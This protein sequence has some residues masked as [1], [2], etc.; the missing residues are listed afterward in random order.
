MEQKIKNAHPHMLSAESKSVGLFYA[1][2]QCSLWRDVAA[3]VKKEKRIKNAL[4]SQEIH[5]VNHH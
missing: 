1:L 4:N 3:E 5:S 2:K